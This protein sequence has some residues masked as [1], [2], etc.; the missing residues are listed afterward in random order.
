MDETTEPVP[1]AAPAPENQLPGDGRPTAQIPVDPTAQVAAQPSE[2]GLNEPGRQGFD[3]P[4]W[5]AFGAGAP[6]RLERLPGV[7]HKRGSP[8][9]T[10]PS[11]RNATR[12]RGNATRHRGNAT[13]RRGNAARPTTDRRGTAIPTARFRSVGP[14]PGRARLLGPYAVAR[15][16]PRVGMDRLGA[17]AP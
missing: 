7:A 15:E 17:T 8:R 9:N 16:H 4:G 14:L 11:W 3:A 5:S 12:H 13:R 10:P 1:G 6:P 2:L